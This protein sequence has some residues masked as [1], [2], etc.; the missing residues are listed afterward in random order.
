MA[1]SP[2]AWLIKASWAGAPLVLSVLPATQTGRSWLYALPRWSVSCVRADGALSPSSQGP[3][4]V[5]RQKAGGARG[6]LSAS[7]PGS[8]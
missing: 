7:G 2:W 8:R 4:L 5:Q 3:P 1:P 6:R